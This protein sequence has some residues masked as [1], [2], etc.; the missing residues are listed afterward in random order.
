ML[1]KNLGGDRLG[2]GNKM[3]IQMRNYER[4]THDLSYLWRSTMATGT[5]VPY[6][7]ILG[8]PGDTF[9]INLNAHVLTLPTVGPLFG[10][11]KLQLDVFICPLRLYNAQLHM[12][13]LNVGL[14]MSKVKFPIGN[15]A[16]SSLNSNNDLPIEIRQISQSSL[17]AYLGHRGNGYYN[18]TTA[19]RRLINAI[20]ILAY[21]DIYKNYYA[22]KMENVG[23]IIQ[24]GGS[25]Q[26]KTFD[27]QTGQLDRLPL[28]SNSHTSE[29]L[30]T[31]I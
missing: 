27:N 10:S 6:M 4:S 28:V 17:M 26:I 29:G 18:N 15:I 24:G 5:L 11:F 1:S 21:Y 19:P 3:R 8:L 20:P 25:S 23:Y 2:S 31:A 22:N 16:T 12:N 9:D 14:D 30:T 7:K 13:K